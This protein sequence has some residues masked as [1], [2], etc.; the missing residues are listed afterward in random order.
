METT[1]GE[2][3]E[4]YWGIEMQALQSAVTWD[5]VPRNQVPRATNVLPWTWLYKLKHS[6]WLPKKVQGPIVHSW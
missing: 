3:G 2:H 1:N 6:R 5:L 4:E